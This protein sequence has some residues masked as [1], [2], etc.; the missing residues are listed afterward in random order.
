MS[1]SNHQSFISDE[2][3]ICHKLF[4]AAIDTQPNLIVLMH[5]HTPILFNKAFQDFS[6]IPNVKMFLREFGSLPNRFKSPTMPIF[7][8]EK[9][10]ISINGPL[11]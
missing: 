11:P 7:M 8:P 1:V 6:G 10:P 3:D 4:E 2:N 9:H 5:D